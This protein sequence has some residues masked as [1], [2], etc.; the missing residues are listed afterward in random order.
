MGAVQNLRYHIVLVSKF[1]KP[2]FSG[3]ENEVIDAFS[4]AKERSSFILEKVA[5][6]N[7]D[8][9]HLII[10]TTGTY[11]LSKTIGRVKSIT[12]NYLWDRNPSHL[13]RFYW[14]KNKKLLWSGGYYAATVGD[15]SVEHIERYLK[16]QGY[17]K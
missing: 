17:W 15:V 13:Q 14:R 4:V 1:R 10:R 3:I 9:V 2:V 6:E 5:V 16:K 11:S 7:N 12:S 8:H